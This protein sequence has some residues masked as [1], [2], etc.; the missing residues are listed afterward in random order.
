[1]ANRFCSNCG[2]ELGEESRFCPN[3][4]RSLSNTASMS[5]PEA[6][7]STPIPSTTMQQSSGSG[8]R[9]KNVAIGCVGVPVVLVFLIVVLA[10]IGSGGG[11][12]TSEQGQASQQDSG[13]QGA[14]ADSSGSGQDNA[15]ALGNTAQN[16]SLSWTI[17][18]VEQTDEIGDEFDSMSGNFVVVDFQVENTGD[19][20]AT[21]DYA[22][23][24]LLDSQGREYE[25]SI[26]ASMY[27]PTELD[28]FYTDISPGVTSEFRAVYEVAP[29]AEGLV[30]EATS[31]SFDEG[32]SYL[33][34]G[35]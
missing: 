34:L 7:T 17:T 5:T 23:L 28:P 9:W 35:I 4:G 3:C 10:A 32:Y 29:E 11:T 25:P 8:H 15:V 30:L 2:R 33:S 21:I 18:N 14:S 1:M 31:E 20:A 19:Q 26:D 27:V 12:G 24:L 16:G 22:Y 6:D 13:N